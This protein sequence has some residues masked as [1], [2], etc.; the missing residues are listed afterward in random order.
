M[1]K[2]FLFSFFSLLFFSGFSQFRYFYGTFSGASEVP[3]NASTATGIVIVK[4]YTSSKLVELWGNYNGL[5]ANITASHIHQAAAGANGGV[6][7]G[8]ANTGG[9][10]GNLTGSAT[11]SAGQETELLAGNMYANVHT[12]SFP[13]GEIRAQLT[14]VADGDGVFLNA[15][16][17]SSQEV[18]VNPSTATGFSNVLLER[19]TNK[20][21]LTG[22]YAN[23]TTNI[24]NQHIH[25]G[26]AGISGG[27]IIG[28]T[29]SGGTSGTLHGTG[30]FTDAQEDS[31]VNAKTY[32]NVHSTTYP[33]GEIRGQI[34]TFSQQ[35][36]FG[37]RLGGVNEVPANA[38]T[39]RGT[40]IVRFNTATNEL[41]L[42]GNYEGLSAAITGSHIHNAAAGVNGPVVVGLTN[43]GGTFGV[44]G[45]SATLTDP[46]ETALMNG[47][48]YV[49]VHSSSFPGGEIR[50][51]LMAGTSGETQYSQVLATGLQEVPANI[52]TGTGGVVVMVDKI[53]GQ[54]YVTGGFTGLSGNVSNAHIHQ[55][56]AGSNGGVIMPLTFDGTTLG[57]VSGSQVL[58]P[59]QVDAYINGLT[60]I[61]IHSTSFPG[62]EIRAQL[63]NLVLPVKLAY[64][65]GY[66]QKN[67]AVLLWEAATELNVKQYEVEQQNLVT[68]TWMQKAIVPAKESSPAVYKA[69]DLPVFYNQSFANYRLRMVDKDGKAAYSQVVKISFANEQSGIVLLRNPVNTS[70]NFMV[71]GL[72]NNQQAEAAILD[73]NGRK[74]NRTVISGGGNQQMNTSALSGGVYMLQVQVGNEMMIKRFLKQ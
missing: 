48:M 46:Q 17:Q 14:P 18:P 59:T 35:Q 32:V 19:S 52:S 37:G 13:G 60:Y 11:L 72:S 26:R 74:L 6:V 65:N 55:A 3:A 2:L 25:M 8:L 9:I 51:Q 33:G 21:W 16:L 71:N 42:T 27:V 50:A 43:S 61:N 53:T 40:V 67:T 5:S 54:T 58:T 70:L 29:N 34:T 10:S 62:G 39:A 73:Y 23:L 36:F 15:R 24:S 66:R 7:V 41:E 64:F 69:E 45:V 49:N 47:E 68:G 20:V 38:S 56:A 57:V 44:L 31:L 4:F 22:S 28:L 63:G 12:S 1:R 30:T